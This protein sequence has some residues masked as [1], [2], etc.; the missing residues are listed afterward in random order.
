MKIEGFD[1]PTEEMNVF[2]FQDVVDK[3]INDEVKQKN[4][5][6][7]QFN[8]HSFFIKISSIGVPIC[9]VKKHPNLPWDWLWITQGATLEDIIN[10]PDLPWRHVESKFFDSLC[11]Y[12]KTVKF[13]INKLHDELDNIYN[14][15]GVKEAQ[16]KL[17]AGE[18][19]PL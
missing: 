9:Y 11:K 16:D 4:D 6:H 5:T 13:D 15:C 17:R 7:E 3:L 12:G 18:D 1:I 14:W 2:Q 8:M 19:E 10:N